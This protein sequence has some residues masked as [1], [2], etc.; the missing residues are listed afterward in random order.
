VSDDS[1]I[2]SVLVLGYYETH[3]S[4]TFFAKSTPTLISEDSDSG[5]TIDEYT[6]PVT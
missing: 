5:R 4:D 2:R 1:A 6:V 3:R